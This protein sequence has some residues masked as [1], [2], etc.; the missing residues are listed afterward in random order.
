MRTGGW[1][2]L[3]ELRAGGA[4]AAIGLG[5]N[6]WQPCASMLELADP[7]LFLLAGRYTLLEQA[8]LE[9]FVSALRQ[10]GCGHCDRR[11]VQFGRARRQGDIRLCGCT[12]RHRGARPQAR[13][14]LSFRMAWSC[15][16]RHCSSSPRI[17][18]S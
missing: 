9:M 18:L 2:A 1:R 11:A 14:H 6:E 10:S 7:D 8:P 4:V 5:V 3:D 16:R 15:A 12:A 13:K 17:P